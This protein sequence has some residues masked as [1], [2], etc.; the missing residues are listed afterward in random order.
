ML[1]KKNSA[2]FRSIGAIAGTS[3]TAYTTISTS[4]KSH[5]C[6]EISNRTFPKGN[7]TFLICTYSFLLVKHDIQGS[8][9]ASFRAF[10]R[11]FP[12]AVLFFSVFFF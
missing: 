8:C 9:I 10:C 6:A 7:A 5:D 2:F 12:E 1:G 11:E 4:K 3:L